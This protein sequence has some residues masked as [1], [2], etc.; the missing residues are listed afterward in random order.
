MDQ[1]AFVTPAM[2]EA[3]GEFGSWLQ[4][5]VGPH[6]A[7]LTIHRYLSFFLQ[8]EAE[9][10]RI[11]T[12]I[13]LL[14]HFTAEGLRRVRLPMQWLHEVRGMEPDSDARRDDSERR[15]VE[16]LAATFPTNSWA[17]RLFTGYHNELMGRH[18][19]GRTSMRSVRMALRPAV[20]LLLAMEAKEHRL[21]DQPTLD[22]YL[23]DAPGQKAAI[24]GFIRFLQASHGLDLA[25][26][27]DAKKTR[28]ARRRKL[29]RLII[30]MSHNPEEGDE[31]LRRWISAGLEYFHGIKVGKQTIL[32]ATV[33]KD[34]DGLRIEVTKRSYFL[35]RWDTV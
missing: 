27:I 13:E 21:P 30:H 7:A 6:K 18:K 24:T 1:E 23:L 33:A 15:Q 12:Y 25:I 29:E 17:S 2:R 20:S 11:P 31:F 19:A 16:T 22:R 35:P 26:R 34:D 4:I 3:F 14:E 9:W 5:K 28:A 8:M 32:G 10:K